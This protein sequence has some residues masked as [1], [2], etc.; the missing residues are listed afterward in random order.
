MS[1][2]KPV[3]LIQFGPLHLFWTTGVYYLWELKDKYDL[4]LVDD[5]YSNSF[6][7]EKI[8]KYLD[9]KFI[10]Y[11][12]KNKGIKLIKNLY[13]DYTEIFEKYDPYKILMYNVSFIENQVLLFVCNKNN[14]NLKIFQYQN[15]KSATNM[16]RDREYE[17]YIQAVILTKK[18]KYF[19]IFLEF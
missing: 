18:F 16:V 6:N 13:K 4:L 11:Q 9:I 10:Y 3:L 12:K 8:I 14:K 1:K 19:K 7:F 5:E 17:I 15:S 2:T